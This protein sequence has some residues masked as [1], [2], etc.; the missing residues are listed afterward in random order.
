[1]RS[2]VLVLLAL[3]A[4]SAHAKSAA[5]KNATLKPVTFELARD[6]SFK[7]SNRSWLKPGET[8]SL[9][10]TDKGPTHI[11]Y[12]NNGAWSE[13][14]KTAILA[15]GACYEFKLKSGLTTG[16]ETHLNQVNCR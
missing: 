12:Y 6:S 4:V 7:A 16:I 9:R 13:D 5:I 15:P 1:M 2:L 11:R 10:G 14:Y 3:S 8:Q